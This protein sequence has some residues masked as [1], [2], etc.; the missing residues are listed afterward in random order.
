MVGSTVAEV[1]CHPEGWSHV[2][3]CTG[4]LIDKLFILS[5]LVPFFAWVPKNN[6]GSRHFHIFQITEFEHWLAFILALHFFLELGCSAL[7]PLEHGGIHPRKRNYD[8]GNVVQFFCLE[9]YSLRGAEL[10]QCYYFGWYPEP[11][12]CEGNSFLYSAC[13]LFFP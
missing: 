4:M 10:I 9:G 8:E 6:R 7:S 2:P 1:V 13:F 3:K 12:I 11:P 5:C